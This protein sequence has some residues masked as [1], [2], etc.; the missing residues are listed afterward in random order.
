MIQNRWWIYVQLNL[1]KW[2]WFH[3][4]K[5]DESIQLYHRATLCTCNLNNQLWI[6]SCIK[7]SR[8]LRECAQHGWECPVFQCVLRDLEIWG[9]LFLFFIF[10]LKKKINMGTNKRKLQDKAQNALCKITDHLK[11][12]VEIVEFYHEEN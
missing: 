5:I 3:K 2:S 4:Y 1:S 7:C 10:Y 8:V 12:E 9:F 11:K 6:E